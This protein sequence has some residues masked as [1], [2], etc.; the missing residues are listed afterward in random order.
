MI[1]MVWTLRIIEYL[2]VLWY[3]LLYVPYINVNNVVQ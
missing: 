3:N 1:R 2:Y